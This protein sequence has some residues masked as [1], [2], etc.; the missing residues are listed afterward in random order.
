MPINPYYDEHIR[1]L[2]D[3]MSGARSEQ[4]IRERLR[5]LAQHRESP[6]PWTSPDVAVG[7]TGVPGPHGPVPVRTYRPIRRPA[8]SALLWVH[9]GGFT[10]GD[11]E[12]PE[13]HR[14]SGEL[15][16][17]ADAFV[18]S[19]GYRLA[20]DG[21]RYP[22][23]LDDVHAAW[24]WLCTTGLP[25]GSDDLPI[26]LGGASAGAALALA[27]ALRT[28]DHGDRTADAL[29]LAYPFTHFPA[30]ALD[31]ATA[32]EMSTLPAL[33]RFAPQGIEHMVRSYVGRITDLPTDA[34]PG[35]A[36]L[37]GLPRTHLVLSGYDD[38]RPSGELLHRQLDEV[39]VQVTSY[40]ADSMLHGHLDLTAP[41]PQVEESLDFFA[42]ALREA[43]RPMSGSAAGVRATA[44][45]HTAAQQTPPVG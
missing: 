8:T 16:L 6:E 15:A 11:L 22:V 10:G 34:L 40:L 14:V 17:R 12:M 32:V 4:E 29:L 30:P 42:A 45:L 25:P 3:V 9:G 13:A 41:L 27:T 1:A 19:V 31:T 5:E 24:S 26:A 20:G 36:P 39:G 18:V 23:P 21:I 7:D 35:T 44:G 33:A 43:V 28:R 37:A 2:A 38:L